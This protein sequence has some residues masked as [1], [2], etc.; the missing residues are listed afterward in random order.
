[1]I[2]RLDDH[3][4]DLTQAERDQITEAIGVLRMTRRAVV[5]LGM[6]ITLE[7]QRPAWRSGRRPMSQSTGRTEPLS[8]QELPLARARWRDT[9]RRRLQ[10]HNPIAAQFSA[11]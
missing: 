8:D 5:H 6:P 1:L 10:V 9:A 2:R 3:V 7:R 4:D 11:E